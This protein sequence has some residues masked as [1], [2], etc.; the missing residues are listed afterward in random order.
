MHLRQRQE[1]HEGA[2]ANLLS[3]KDNERLA[4]PRLWVGQSSVQNVC[5]TCFALATRL[6]Y[7]DCKFLSLNSALIYSFIFFFLSSV[8][9]FSWSTKLTLGCARSHWHQSP[10][11]C[12][13][14]LVAAISSAH[15]IPC[16]SRRV[17]IS[18]IFFRDIWLKLWLN[19]RRSSSHSSAAKGRQEK[20]SWVW[21]LE[22]C[23]RDC[24]FLCK[25]SFKSRFR[26][27]ERFHHENGEQ[28]LENTSTGIAVDC[29]YLAQSWIFAPGTG[30]HKDAAKKTGG[31]L[32]SHH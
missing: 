20:W 1:T 4:R 30:F 32:R 15:V 6:I 27:M 21:R 18:N 11:S 28:R 7:A 31:L 19:F 5:D 14:L 25:K 22:L 17:C 12:S 13:M 29:G 23:R 3:P 8:L 16:L 9:I 26:T 10:A 24:P 2:G